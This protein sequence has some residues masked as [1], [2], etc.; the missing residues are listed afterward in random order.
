MYDLSYARIGE[1]TVVSAPEVTFSLTLD[2]AVYFSGPV[3][4]RLTLRAVQPSPLSLNFRTSQ[5]FDLVVK[6]GAGD[7]V[8]R[9][10]DGRGFAQVLHSLSLGAG[11]KNFTVQFPLADSKGAALPAGVYTAEAWLTTEVPQL[12]R[13][14]VAF[15]IRPK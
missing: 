14:Q 4:A 8:Y 1:V 11:E 2:S 12:Y 15:E 3:M 9:W 10:S 5:E 13:A 6:N 7:M